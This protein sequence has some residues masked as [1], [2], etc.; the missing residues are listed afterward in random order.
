MTSRY[1]GLVFLW[2]NSLSCEY[3]RL[4]T[5]IYI[6]TLFIQYV[7]IVRHS[8]LF[9]IG[10]P[11]LKKSRAELSLTDF[12]FNRFIV[13]LLLLLSSS[14]SLSIFSGYGA[15]VPVLH[16]YC[17]VIVTCAVYFV[18]CSFWFCVFVLFLY[19]VYFSSCGDFITGTCAV[20][21]PR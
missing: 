11:K 13:L 8:V 9:T 6:Y 7:S 5:N 1:S 3:I 14:S 15:F 16:L 21:P 18:L 2:N 10:L 20:L 4:N 19:Y 12:E 17:F